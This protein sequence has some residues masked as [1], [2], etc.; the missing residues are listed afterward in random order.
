VG[1]LAALAG[2]AVAGGRLEYEARWE[3]LGE[4]ERR[5]AVRWGGVKLRARRASG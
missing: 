2:D 4:D 3:V 1:G 5:A